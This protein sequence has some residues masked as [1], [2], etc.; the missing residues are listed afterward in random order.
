ML[1]FPSE[2]A[3]RRVH[4]WT[5]CVGL[6]L[7]APTAGAQDAPSWS[8]QVTPYLWGSG[9]DGELVPFTG[10]PRISL[11][12][13]FS[14]VLE[15]LDGAF[16]LSA[17]ARHDRVVMLGDFSTSSSSKEG[18]IPPGIPAEGE[19]KQRSLTLAV[20]WRAIDG[21]GMTLDVLGGLRHWNVRSSVD[22]P[23]VGISRSPSDD[24]TDPILALRANVPLS[25]RWS[26]VLYADVGGAGVGSDHTHQFVGTL[27]FQATERFYLSGGYRRLDVDYASGGTRVDVTLD[28]PL[29]GATW[30]F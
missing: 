25:T 29:V 9:I 22:V 6:L 2:R 7:L 16:F 10:A 15:D 20:G 26:T 5:T 18:R 12:R 17:F 14:E 27:N 8:A 23:L 24:F 11:E 28:G 4:P 3:G 30:R 1:Q 19:L 13:S 21:P